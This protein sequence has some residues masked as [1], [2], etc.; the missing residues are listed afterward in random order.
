MS[1][2][3]TGTVTLLKSVIG[4]EAAT[5]LMQS[6]EFGGMSLEIPKTDKGRGA[7]LVAHLTEV[8]GE[9][10][11]IALIAHFGGEKIY[12]PRDA[13]VARQQRNK[14]IIY[15][16]SSGASVRELVGQYTLSDR[17]IRSILNNHNSDG[18]RITD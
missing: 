6:K 14:N 18:S 3:A 9:A 13:Q 16:Y 7:P 10:A 2:N 5:Q 17:H 1:S 12:I 4:N 11:V 15:Q 8:I